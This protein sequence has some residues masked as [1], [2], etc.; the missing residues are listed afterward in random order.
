MEKQPEPQVIQRVKLVDG[1]LVS[2]RETN[3]YVFP[4]NPVISTQP[5]LTDKEVSSSTPVPVPIKTGPAPMFSPEQE[6]IFSKAIW[7][8]V[9]GESQQ[10]Q[11]LLNELYAQ[12]PSRGIGRAWVRLFQSLSLL[13]EKEKKAIL[14]TYLQEIRLTQS[15]PLVL[16]PYHSKKVVI[17]FAQYLLNT[18]DQITL[19]R[20]MTKW[21]E[22]FQDLTI[23][24]VGLQEFLNEE[25]QQA[26]TL[27][28]Q[29]S[30]KPIRSPEWVYHL[31]P[32]AD[33]LLE[34]LE[35]WKITQ[36]E[37]SVWLLRDAV[38]KAAG[39]LDAFKEVSHPL[40]HPVIEKEKKSI[41]QKL[42]G[43]TKREYSAERRTSSSSGDSDKMLVRQHRESHSALIKTHAFS[44]ALEALEKLQPQLSSRG[45]QEWMTLLRS[46]YQQLEALKDFI[47]HQLNTS[48]SK[49]WTVRGLGGAVV[50]ANRLGVRVAVGEH[51]VVVK[52]WD[53]LRS[54]AFLR[55]VEVGLLDAGLEVKEQARYYAACA[56]Y[57]FEI[58]REGK[59]GMY[60]KKAIELDPQREAFLQSYQLG[61]GK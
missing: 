49:S 59:A 53:G 55:L 60:M 28:S 19:Y 47:I 8:W 44:K 37:V 3:R 45:S 13:Q 22:A 57:C 33:N 4:L 20:R 6:E 16:D 9:E 42:G 61:I 41:L 11:T 24:I 50:G 5:V 35:S 23:C 2:V 34:Q 1:K 17:S 7:Q 46:G 15:D 32:L 31:Q 27:F 56:M 14:N 58:G 29:Y 40:F 39:K 26:Q 10:M 52:S 12:L 43:P 38:Q 51:G 36:A 48:A 25:A 18:I 54:S 21:T 30:A